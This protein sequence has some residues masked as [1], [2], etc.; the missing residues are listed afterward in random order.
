M[1]SLAHGLQ[2]RADLPIPG[3]LFAWAAA[4]VLAVSFF[5]LAVL[6]QRPL[7]ET[8]RPRPLVRMPR[9]SAAFCGALGVLLTLFLIYAGFAGTQDPGK[10]I[11][12]TFVYVFF[13]AALPLISALFGDVFRAFNPWLAI[14]RFTRAVTIRATGRRPVARFDYPDRLG[15]RPAVAFLVAFGYV[16]LISTSGRDPSTIAALIVAYS[17]IQFTGMILFG[18]ERWV[19]RGEAFNVY[20]NV[21]SRLAPV[22]VADGRLAV[23]LPLSGLTDMTWLPGGVFFLCT[24]IGITAFDGASSVDAWQGIAES[25][26]NTLRNAGLTTGAAA[27]IVGMLGLIGMI[28]LVAGF[29]RLGVAGM[30]SGGVDMKADRLAQVFA[31]SLVPIMLA[32][33]MAHY[34]SFIL[35]QGQA[36]WPLLSDPL[37]RGEDMFGT[38]HA[39][40]RYGRPSGQT[41]WYF[42]VAILVLGH[43]AALAV[44]HDKAL[45]VW[46]RAGA[47][48]RSQLWML[49]VMVGF[50]NLGLWLLSQANR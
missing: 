23:R 13:W 9:A 30:V 11:V 49:V 17:A 12:P 48:V 36:L 45:A 19:D 26:Q 22:T 44:A 40:V 6:W 33:V 46:G 14:G 27:Q 10:N 20:F 18:T 37:G 29:Y 31:A 38:A 2:G 24:A 25:L 41:I 1:I 16:E 3:W 5:A 4:I 50:T 47:A 43:T 42:Q 39:V 8:A 15:R 28:L 35:F 34:I 32:Y 21:F 7:L